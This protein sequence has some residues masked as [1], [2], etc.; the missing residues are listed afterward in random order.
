LIDLLLGALGK[1]KAANKIPEAIDSFVYGA[2]C[3]MVLGDLQS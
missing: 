2:N 3:P 1:S